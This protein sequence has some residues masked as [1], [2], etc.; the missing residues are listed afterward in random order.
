[1]MLY[2]TLVTRALHPRRVNL[3]RAPEALAKRVSIADF[4]SRFPQLHAI[5]LAELE[6]GLQDSL[7]DLPVRLALCLLPARYELNFRT[8]SHRISTRLFSRS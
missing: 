1:M 3:D 6:R 2:A 8:L 7:D 5:L 4:F